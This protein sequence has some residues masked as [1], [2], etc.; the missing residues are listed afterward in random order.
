MSKHMRNFNIFFVT[1]AGIVLTM[2]VSSAARAELLANGGFET[3]DFTGWTLNFVPPSTAA[4]VW[5]RSFFTTRAHDGDYFVEFS[6]NEG[7]VTGVLSQQFATVA[8][9]DYHFD[10]WYGTVSYIP[11]KASAMLFE[12]LGN[13]GSSVLASRSL[14]IAPN[15]PTD[16]I[17][18]HVIGEFTAD[19][20]VATVRFTDQTADSFVCDALLDT[21]SVTPVP[22]PSTL[23]LL[24][25]GAVSLIFTWCRRNWVS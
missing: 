1:A 15:E 21:V 22:E 2:L 10:F 3:G 7:P 13:D 19:G 23:L 18:E 25:M 11:G 17:Y 8:G 12:A 14:T 4:Q 6:T 24:G 9:S 5:P 16:V 20:S